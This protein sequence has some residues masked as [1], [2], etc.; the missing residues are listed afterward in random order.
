MKN[1]FVKALAL[2]TSVAIIS[3]FIAGC[4]DYTDNGA[5]KSVDF[6]VMKCDSE[7]SYNAK[8]EFT[9]NISVDDTTFA[10]SIDSND[11]KVFYS[12]INFS[13][14]PDIDAA[15]A[16]MLKD[17]EYK[18]VYADVTSVSSVSDHSASV[19]FS[20]KSFST[21][22]PDCFFIYCNENTN[23]SSNRYLSMVTVRYPTYS[24]VSDTTQ[25]H[26][27]SKIDKFKLTL[28]KSTFASDISADDIV[29]SGG[30]EGSTVSELDRT[31]DNML[32][33]VIKTENGYNSGNDGFITVKHSAVTDAPVDV[34]VS[35]GII[36][37]E[38]IFSSSSFEASTNYAKATL[39]LSDC[40]FN[41]SVTADSFSCDNSEVEIARFDRV[42]VSEG[43]LYLSFDDKTPEDVISIISDS[44]F[45]VDESALNINSSLSFVINPY[46]PDVTGNI[47]DIKES[48]SDFSVTAEFT[49]TDGVFNVISKNS[50]IFGGDYAK[51]VI[52]SITAQD[53][54]AT[55]CFDIPKTSSA[56]TAELYGTIGLRSGAVLSRWGTQ[57]AIAPFP[58]YFS[59]E[60]SRAENKTQYNE[61]LV[62]ML[63]ALSGYTADFDNDSISPIMNIK[64]GE[65]S[66]KDFYIS[67][68]D[69]F[70]EI[71]NLIVKTEQMVS[72][73][74]VPLSLHNEESFITVN[75]YLHD[76]KALF[77]TVNTL[78]ASLARLISIEEQISSA[79]DVQEL[80]SLNAEKNELSARITAAYT[81]K[82]KGKSFSQL[83]NE[84]INSYCEDNGALVC[85]YSVSDSNY[86]WH[87]Q[88]IND[89]NMFRKMSY[90][91]IINASVIEFYCEPICNGEYSREVL[92]DLSDCLIK[93]SDYAEV[94]AIA[95][96]NGSSVYSTTLGR[97]FSLVK[98]D[99]V[100][101]NPVNEI[102]ISD[103]TQLENMLANGETLSKE[104][105]SVGF[106]ISSVRYLVCSDSNITGRAEI[107]SEQTYS[108]VSR[109]TLYDIGTS[110]TENELEFSN[111]YYSIEI[112]DE[113]MPVAIPYVNKYYQLYTL[114]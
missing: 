9:V 37:P 81:T 24:L 17:G 30:F 13:T 19:T 88:S 69:S 80:D 60:Q 42:S 51:A 75:R 59:A 107:I 104:L 57:S 112:N 95:S 32:S 34:S 86:N 93:L 49:V 98:I 41:D 35:V 94:N 100:L 61:S 20:D 89:K 65:K 78:N 36:S 21:N 55:V 76:M 74:S 62:P 108:F 25:V 90:S 4:S 46:S 29:L 99:S 105:E 113:G 82:I 70:G 56:E 111:Y 50:F 39:E 71:Y 14:L 6:S 5:D 92:K 109:A 18:T 43:V 22:R 77:A 85:F 40:M 67:M 96:I 23:T 54:S 103:I 52:S 106:D 66:F 16:V 28:D 64:V 44:G 38:V 110:K 53:N 87:P 27:N 48:G 114:K 10:D 73:D 47:T 83:L 2:L 1:C 102:S 45:S 79:K 8:G 7:V 84:V 58:L 97:S 3:S 72:H 31:G 11:V 33:L 101:N 68:S 12:D 91:I 26:S 63:S 15:E